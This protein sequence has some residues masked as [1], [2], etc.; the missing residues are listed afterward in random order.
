MVQDFEKLGAFYLG[1]PFDLKEKKA[2]EGLLLYDSKDLVTHAVCVG[3]TGSGKTGLC[4]ALLEEAAIDG[5]P[6]IVIDPKGDLPNLLLTFPELKPQDFA[7]W[8][9]EEDAQKKNLSAAEYAAQQSELWK[10]GL[11]EW[12]QDGNRIQRL[13]DSADF[14]VYTPGSN[15][16]IPVSILKSFSAPPAQIRNDAEL[17]TERVNT[18]V[19]SLLGLIGIDADPIRSREHILMSNV[20]NKEWSDGRDLDIA[21][22]IQQ[23]QSPSLTKIGVMD[24]ESF[25]PAKERF[26]L[27][28]ALNNLLAAPGFANWMEGEP[29]D[30]PQILYTADGKPR[31]AIFSI[32]HLDDAQRMFFVSLLLNQVLGWART[33]TGTTSL[34]TIL[35]MDEIFGYFPPVANPP[36]KLPLLTL[37]KQGRAFGV[38]VVLAT[39]NPV[40]LD[41]KG[42]ANTGTW[43]IGRLQTERDKDRVLEGLEGV[44]TGSGQKFDR[45][46]IEQILAG[47]GS[48][49]F[50]L[51][52]THDDAPEVFESRWA[53]SYLRGPLTRVQ[54]KTLM[55]PVKSQPTTSVPSATPPAATV[56]TSAA[57]KAQSQKSAPVLP[58]DVTQCFI[59]IRSSGSNATLVYL[60]TVLGAAEIR[61]SASKSVEMTEQLSLLAAISDGPVAV[62]WGQAEQLEVPI[63]D[64]EKSP[65][66]EAE[67][68]DI[69]AAG[70]KTRNY[71]S[72]KK[73]IANWI[74]RN[75]RLELMESPKLKIVSNPGESERDFR[76]RLQLLAREQRDA[77]VEKLRQRYAPKIAQLEEKKRRAEQAVAR[78]AEQAKSQKLQTAISFGATLL[79]SFMGRKALSMTTLG[80]ATTAARGVGRSMKEAEDVGRA[81]E[82][83][84]TT[85]QLISEL[86][87]EFKTDVEALDRSFD[88][89]TETLEKV[90]LKPT[91]SNIDIKLV[92][93][94]WAPYWRD[95]QGQLTP[96][97]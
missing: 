31:V 59:P 84:E 72:W 51:N 28:M 92:T 46:E 81:Q 94:A 40:D 55:D 38:G 5:I 43:F 86:D 45:Q 4:I 75:R 69:P 6:S 57:T 71:E 35:Y 11:A 68:A 73:D 32:A 58:P 64:L 54:I 42:L 20:F 7:P 33:Q 29:L 88:P 26:E 47:L 44:A 36:S 27:A 14:R 18:T 21:G 65:E 63:N 52:N 23:I 97:W 12:G 67:F 82:T 41:Y 16:G 30:I 1:R 22:L 96:A 24:L 91:K 25:F 10:K 80:R 49:V 50:L 48:R 17:L 87:G 74:Y 70:T 37:L 79:S 53:M 3:M 77:A 9:N 90:S 8:I 15:A 78:E 83:V 85:S 2:K 56:A 62:D 19:T 39:Q 95:G 13:R 93:F 34:R 76:V 61:Y 60:P 66:R 89:Q